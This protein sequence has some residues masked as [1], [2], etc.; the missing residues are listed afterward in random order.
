MNQ[1]EPYSLQN[2]LYD[3]QL[4]DFSTKQEPIKQVMDGILEA[5]SL[6]TPKTDVE[7]NKIKSVRS[8]EK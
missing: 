6:Y 4:G 5:Y 2:D 1:Q 3:E 7:K 8:K